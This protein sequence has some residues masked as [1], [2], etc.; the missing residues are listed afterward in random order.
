MKKRIV[1]FPSGAKRK[2]GLE[3]FSSLLSKKLIAQGHEVCIPAFFS[4]KLFSYQ[5]VLDFNRK[6]LQW[7]ENN[8]FDIALGLD[9]I[10]KQTHLRAGNGV[11]AAYLDQRR[12][13]CSL[14]RRLS[15]EI[16]PLHQ[17][18]L[19][20]EK[21]AFQNPDLKKLF[22]NSHLAA[23]EVLSY[24]QT[25]PAKICVVH[26]GADFEETESSFA[27]WPKLQKTFCQ[28]HRLPEDAIHL[29][30]IGHGFQRKGL[31]LLLKAL[32]LVKETPIHLSILGEDKRKQHYQHLAEKLY[33]QSKVRFFSK[34][35]PLPLYAMADALVLPTRYDPFANVTV[36]ALCM[37]LFVVTSEKN[38]GKEILTPQTG[39]L[40]EQL[41]DPEELKEKIL[42]IPKKT[43]ET[44]S[45]IRESVSHLSLQNQLQTFIDALLE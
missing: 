18:L 1:L 13:E 19:N 36:E 3:K 34:R 10:A 37:G 40:I 25:D 42:Q 32:A 20:I 7:Q 28:E 29:L 16:N 5:K 15:F 8:F 12:K 30:F 41:S 45:F 17:A 38:G 22:V 4:G 27:S 35:A 31:D 33:L 11:H 2:G 43:K 23:K 39:S 44:A 9:R 21:Q 26:N 14:F 6:A 24:Y